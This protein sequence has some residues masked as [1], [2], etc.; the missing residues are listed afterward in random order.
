[1]VVSPK[2]ATCSKQGLEKR[3]FVP[4]NILDTIYSDKNVIEKFV[5]MEGSPEGGLLLN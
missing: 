4:E 2:S 5:S 3:R 1:M